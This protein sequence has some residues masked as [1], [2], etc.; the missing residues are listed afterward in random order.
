MYFITDMLRRFEN[1]ELRSV[2]GTAF[3]LFQIAEEAMGNMGE[4]S[5][6]YHGEIKEEDQSADE[7]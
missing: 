3:I 2:N 7:F 1:G 6:S 5:V 4:M